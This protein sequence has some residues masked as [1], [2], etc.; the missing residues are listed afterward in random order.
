MMIISPIDDSPVVVYNKRRKCASFAVASLMLVL[1]TT[2]IALPPVRGWFLPSSSSSRIRTPSELASGWVHSALSSSSG[3]Y[4]DNENNKLTS[5]CCGGYDEEKLAMDH[6]LFQYLEE[7]E[8][9]G[10]DA[11]TIR[12]RR[13]KDHQ[14]LRGLYTTTDWNA[15]EYLCALPFS[16]AMILQD[17]TTTTA[18][19]T[20]NL[21][22]EEEEEGGDSFE[23][24]AAREEV[25]LAIL[26][27]QQVLVQKEKQYKAYIDCL[28]KM[29]VE[30]SSS[31]NEITTPDFWTLDEVDQIPVPRLRELTRF[32][33]NLVQEMAHLVP[34]QLS[35]T[36]STAR[37]LNHGSGTSNDNAVQAELLQWAT[38]VIRTRAFTTFRRV[39]QVDEIRGDSEPAAAATA[40]ASTTQ[41][42]KRC[43]LLPLL[44]LV[45]HANAE[46]ANVALEVLETPGDLDSSMFA[47]R[48]IHDI[49]TGDELTMTYGTGLETSLDLLDRYGFWLE[50]YSTANENQDA[51]E[52]SQK[53]DGHN[54]S[55]ALIFGNDHRLDWSLV[56]DAWKANVANNTATQ[57]PNHPCS[58]ESSDYDSNVLLSTA[59]RFNLHLTSLYLKEIRLSE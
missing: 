18:S 25:E 52:G 41:L 37:N 43:F 53:S 34:P 2:I 23:L 58:K 44:D 16:A 19:S 21:L 39:S 54:A 29:M 1:G 22:D 24:D 3:S 55:E 36:L 31:W 11:L 6:E 51:S 47:L 57:Q 40:T 20:M 45:N 17:T 12:T 49:S 30:D 48:A 4:E 9:E 56:E 5:F 8:V 33:K 10:L 27:I 7:Q 59:Q 50:N 46:D 42:Q 14:M 32:R 26:F 35:T 13:N 28:P 15:G 38:W